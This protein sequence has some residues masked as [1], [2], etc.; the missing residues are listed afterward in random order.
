MSQNLLL[1]I[2]H[3]KIFFHYRLLLQVFHYFFRKM[4]QNLFKFLLLSTIF[5]FSQAQENF[6]PQ[7]RKSFSLLRDLICAVADDELAKHPEMRT[8]LLVELQNDFPKTFSAEILKCLPSVVTKVYLNYPTDIYGKF[9]RNLIL[10]KESLVIY[11]TDEAKYLTFHYYTHIKKYDSVGPVNL[12]SKI[13]IVSSNSNQ[14]EKI[15]KLFRRN[16]NIAQIY[17]ENQKVILRSFFRTKNLTT[18]RTFVN[19]KYENLSQIF[20][21]DKSK[22]LEKFPLKVIYTDLRYN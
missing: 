10:P 16:L 2:F 5:A 7:N 19:S 22:N 9:S 1:S 21:P 20:F 8:I 6:L 14:A 13:L 17:E 15:E 18:F 4:S 12:L 11:V 3:Q